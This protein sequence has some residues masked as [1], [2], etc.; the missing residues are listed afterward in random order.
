M[1]NLVIIFF[2]WFLQSLIAELQ[3]QFAFGQTLTQTAELDIS[4]TGD[5]I[6][7]KRLKHNHFVNP[8]DKLRPEVLGQGV[9]HRR[10]LRF[11]ITWRR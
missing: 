6:L 11:A 10:M 9:H 4:D 3:I 2:A 5:L 7:A 1:S 8:V